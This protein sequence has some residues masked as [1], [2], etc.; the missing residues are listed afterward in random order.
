MSVFLR[1]ELYKILSVNQI[2]KQI[3]KHTPGVVV[4]SV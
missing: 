2:L 3:L 1:K 4:F